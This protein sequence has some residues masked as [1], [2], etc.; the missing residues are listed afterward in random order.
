MDCTQNYPQIL[1]SN[2]RLLTTTIAQKNWKL[3]DRRSCYQAWRL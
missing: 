2:Y 3:W 1:K